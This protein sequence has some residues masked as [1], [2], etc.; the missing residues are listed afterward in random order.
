MLTK[1][2]K[3]NKVDREITHIDISAQAA[4]KGDYKYYM[5]KKYEQPEAVSNTIDGRIGGE[6]V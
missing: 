2:M 4:S 6:D 5:E 1:S 3:K